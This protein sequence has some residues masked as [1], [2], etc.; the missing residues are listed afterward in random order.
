[1]P[2]GL[3]HGVAGLQHGVC[4]VFPGERLGKAPRKNSTSSRFR[5][6]RLQIDREDAEKLQR[7]PGVEPLQRESSPA[8]GL[9]T[10]AA[11]R[12]TLGS[13]GRPGAM[14]GSGSRLPCWKT[15][16]AFVVGGDRVGEAAHTHSKRMAGA[17]SSSGTGAAR[18]AAHL[19]LASARGRLTVALRSQACPAEAPLAD[20]YPAA[21]LA[22]FTLPADQVRNSPG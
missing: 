8:S 14:I 17:C 15:T 6:H 21:R 20:E 3:D 18:I 1:M 4:P 12:R 11:R 10:V 7:L 9:S 5:Q 22:M 19:V 16:R 2:V 13:R